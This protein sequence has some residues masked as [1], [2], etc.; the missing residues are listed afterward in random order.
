MALKSRI[1]GVRLL[2]VTPIGIKRK[3]LLSDSFLGPVQNEIF[4][5][6]FWGLIKIKNC[7]VFKNNARPVE[8]NF[9]KSMNS[10]AATVF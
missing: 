2:V 10:S 3:H 6:R 7:G 1:E 9:A 5:I 8:S 4:M